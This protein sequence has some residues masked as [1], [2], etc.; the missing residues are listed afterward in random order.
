[1]V[2]LLQLTVLRILQ[3]NCVLCNLYCA[4][5]M[6]KLV[7]GHVRYSGANH[8]LSAITIMASNTSLTMDH[9]REIAEFISPFR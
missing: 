1:M 9:D 6:F 4:A 8:S 3:K 7:L 2:I 5:A